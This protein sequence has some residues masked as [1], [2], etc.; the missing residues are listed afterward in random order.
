L[1]K[2]EALDPDNAT[3]HALLGKLYQE[4][5][6]PEMAIAELETAQR[7]RANDQDV[8]YRLHRLYSRN[9]D[10]AN[11][12]RTLKLLKDLIANRYNESVND[13]NASGLNN[14]GME[15][16]WRNSTGQRARTLR[17]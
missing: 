7:L 4:A 16:L 15:E 12:D 3:T 14:E 2:S 10:T 11:A 13:A 17:T 6:K 9:G 8:L 1:Q 5:G